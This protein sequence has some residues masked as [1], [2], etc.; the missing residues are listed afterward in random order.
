LAVNWSLSGGDAISG[1][2]HI[3]S[4]GQYTPPNYLTEDSVRV[5]ATASLGSDSSVKAA[6]IVKVTPGFLQPLSPENAAMG[7]NG[8]VNITG[9]ISEAGG[10]EGI[11]FEISSSPDGTGNNGQGTLS[12]KTCRRNSQVYTSCTVTFTAPS[13]L[14]GTGITYVVA[15]LGNSPA[16]TA[17]RILLNVEGVASS[18]SAH[19]SRFA[20]PMQLGSSGGNNVDYDSLKNQIVD[21][22]SGT[23]GALLKGLDNRQYILSNN[24]VLARSDQAK[25]GDTIIQ[26]G[27]I[28]NNCSPNGDGPGTT[29]VGY[30]TGWLALNSPATNADAAIAQVT[31]GTVDSAGSI[32]E[33]GGKRAD[34]TLASAPPGVSSTGGRGEAGTLQMKVAKSGRTTGQTCASITALS[35]DVNVDYFF[36]CAETQPYLSKT[37]TNQLAISGNG[38]IDAGDSGALVLDAANAEPVGL[39]FAGGTDTSGVS[40]AIAN[41]VSDVLGELSAQVGNGSS[42]TFVGTQDH[43]VTCLNYGDSTVETAQR[44]VLTDGETERAL[45]GISQARTLI[46]PLAG[47]L[48]VAPGKSNDH[49]GEA[50]VIIYTD[51]TMQVNVP[52]TVGSTRTVVIPSNAHAVAFGSSPLTSSIYSAP[53]LPSSIFAQAVEIKQQYGPGLMKLNVAFFAVGVGQS[54]DNPKEAALVVFVDRNKVTSELPQTIGGLRTRYIVMDRLHVT[55]SYSEPARSK[56][57]CKPQ[58]RENG[59]P[60][61]KP[62]DLARPLAIDLD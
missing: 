38:F 61:S 12:G 18:P 39:F 55:R 49:P 44:R 57:H 50:A 46:N 30:L 62:F 37:F 27:L 41:P 32:L 19:K 3:T 29:P 35:L 16:R 26:P 48:G 20:A 8:T 45:Q 13:L 10:T 7:A 15:R 40:H 2:G 36:D 56:L 14:T 42:Y 17:T 21:C 24:H 11:D 33:M 47:I 43:A 4:S 52:A 53:S 59:A 31:S 22:C 34:G 5:V 54:L 25:I 58:S 9:Y 23:L 1:A 28:D 6:A 60:D 51:E